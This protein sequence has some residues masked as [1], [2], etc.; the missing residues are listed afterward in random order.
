V[1]LSQAPRRRLV[2][3]RREN[4]IG[5]GRGD[6]QAPCRSALA[7]FQRRRYPAQTEV[8]SAQRRQP[9]RL[10]DVQT[11]TALREPWRH[12][13]LRGPHRDNTAPTDVCKGRPERSAHHFE[14]GSAPSST[15]HIKPRSAVRTPPRSSGLGS[16]ATWRW[17]RRFPVADAADDRFGSRF[18]WAAISARSLPSSPARPSDR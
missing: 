12:P 4:R 17:P 16:R 10:G 7:A 3:R 15:A 11:R 9:V 5:R 6:R 18:A 13:P 1:G 8:L 2:A 14:R